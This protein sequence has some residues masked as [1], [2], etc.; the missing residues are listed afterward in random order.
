MKKTAIRSKLPLWLIVVLAMLISITFLKIFN[1]PKEVKPEL[2][3]ARVEKI[4]DGDTLEVQMDD[5][6]FHILELAHIDAPEREQPYGREV[7][8][9][10]KF[11]LLNNDILFKNHDDK[12]EV[13]FQGININLELVTQGMAWVA[14]EPKAFPNLKYY[15]QAE[16]KA[17]HQGKGIW[18]LPHDLRIPPWLWRQQGKEAIEG[19]V[20]KPRENKSNIFPKFKGQLMPPAPVQKQQQG[21]HPANVQKGSSKHDN[22]P[23]S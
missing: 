20:F 16:E 2:E 9:Y 15:Q 1:G 17:T 7:I 23:S 4:F 13:F 12:Q 6:T 8:D 11:Q 21:Q 22:K 3:S 10:L 14:G 18:K 19:K 5:G